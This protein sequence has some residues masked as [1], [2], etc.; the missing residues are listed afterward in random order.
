MYRKLYKY[1]RQANPD[2]SRIQALKMLTL[3]KECSPKTR[4]LITHWLDTHEIPSYQITI[5]TKKSQTIILTLRQIVEDMCM[6]PLQAIFFLD[7]LFRD[8]D[9][10][11]ASLRHLDTV[12]PVTK[13]NFETHVSS[14]IQEMVK[15]EVEKEEAQLRSEN[16]DLVNIVDE[17]DNE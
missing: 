5:N 16:Q 11:M 17:N 8:P 3:V 7:W 9:A 1:L 14:R 13:N 12:I 4:E 10:A 15:C 2:M 6:T